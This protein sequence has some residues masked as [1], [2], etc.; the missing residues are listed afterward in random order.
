VYE[1]NAAISAYSASGEKLEAAAGADTINSYRARERL[2]ADLCSAVKKVA[3]NA[4]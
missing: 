2:L 3:K 1:K 4:V